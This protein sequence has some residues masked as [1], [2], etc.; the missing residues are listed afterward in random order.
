MLKAGAIWV[1]CALLA[2]FW[3]IIHPK[4]SYQLISFQGEDE[5]GI[6]RLVGKYRSGP[7]YHCEEL[8][9]D[10]CLQLVQQEGRMWFQDQCSPSKAQPISKVL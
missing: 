5:S 4:I 1:M 7:G 6:S 9:V 3:F 2:R 8:E 10:A